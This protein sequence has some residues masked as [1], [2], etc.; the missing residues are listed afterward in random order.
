[1]ADPRIPPP[2]V[3]SGARELYEQAESQRA[4]SAR[5]IRL[6]A[7]LRRSEGPR[8]GQRR[9][10]GSD[11][12]RRRRPGAGRPQHRRPRR[13]H[14]AC[15]AAAP[16]GGQ[17]R[18]RAA[19]GRRARRRAL[20]RREAGCPLR[21]P[22]RA[23]PDSMHLR[24]R[25]ATGRRAD[26]RTAARSEHRSRRSSWPVWWLTEPADRRR[27]RGPHRLTRGHDADLRPRL[28][29][30]RHL[31][32]PRRPHRDGPRARTKHEIW[33]DPAWLTERATAELQSTN[34]RTTS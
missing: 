29:R 2:S 20:E 21:R 14:P 15:P 26:E 16:H 4:K 3:E 6:Q 23:G 25:R 10:D 24:A 11:L 34:E 19:G 31:L 28:Q 7:Q 22:Q 33:P 13:H 9:R 30:G 18:A 27:Q 1:M 32:P 8:G 5:G 12:E 17:A